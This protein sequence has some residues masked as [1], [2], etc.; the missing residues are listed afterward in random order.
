VE[1]YLA[2]DRAAEVK[3]EYHDGELFPL[4]AVTWAHAQINFRF[5]VVLDRQLAKTGCQ[6]V[7]SSLRVQVHP[8]KFLI[9]DALVV[10]GKP[11]FTDEHNDTITNPRVIVEVLSPSTADYDYGGKFNLYRRLSS[12]EEYVLISQHQ[13]L[14]ETFRKTPHN[15]WVLHT[16]EGLD[17]TVTIKGL[18]VSVS[19]R[20]A[21]EGVALSAASE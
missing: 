16:D 4:E 1:E 13:A 14:V 5:A 18:G 8:T 11:D 9:P 3:I 10:C 2:L 19:L 17:A 15:E 7:P 21:Y 12:L 6:V 20:E